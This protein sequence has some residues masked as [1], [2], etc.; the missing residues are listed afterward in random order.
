MEWLLDFLSKLLIYLVGAIGAVLA[1]ALLKIHRLAERVAMLEQS[2][3]QLPAAIDELK[4][5]LEVARRDLEDSRRD[6]ETQ[7]ERLHDKL[8]DVRKELMSEIREGDKRH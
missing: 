8:D 1:W 7:I 5:M 4:A 3:G 6:R 2:V